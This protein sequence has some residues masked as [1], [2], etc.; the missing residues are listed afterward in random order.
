[1]RSS[2]RKTA[3]NFKAFVSNTNSSIFTAIARQT[4]FYA[5]HLLTKT[6]NKSVL[7]ECNVSVL[8][9]F[10][11]K[12]N[13]DLYVLQPCFC[14]SRFHICRK[15]VGLLLECNWKTK[16]NKTKPTT[17]NNKSVKSIVSPLGSNQIV[18]LLLNSFDF[19]SF[20]KSRRNSDSLM[21]SRANLHFKPTERF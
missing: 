12:L 18:S 19:D 8:G 10:Q 2:Y 21:K 17:H 6:Y 16:Q 14:H 7:K 15:A 11:H 5:P 4:C 13:W 20:I 3:Q 9:L 1:M